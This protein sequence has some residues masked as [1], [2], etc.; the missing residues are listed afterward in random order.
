MEHDKLFEQFTLDLFS[1]LLESASTNEVDIIINTF[2]EKIC[3]YFNFETAEIYLPTGELLIL[4]GVYGLDR[5]HVCKI[6]YPTSN[7]FS[8][9]IFTDKETYIGD[10]KYFCDDETF[11]NYKT[12]LALPISSQ[13]TPIGMLVI[14]SKIDSTQDFKEDLK[15][16]EF[17]SS[18]FAMHVKNVLQMSM[19]QHKSKQLSSLSKLYL[20]LGEIVNFEGFMDYMATE[21]VH[22]FS[23][24]KILIKVKQ[25]N[26]TTLVGK[27]GNNLD[28]DRDILREN[29][30]LLNFNKKELVLINDIHSKEEYSFLKSIAERSIMFHPIT[31][32][33][34]LSGYIVI[35]D[36]LKT[37]E[38]PLGYF[39]ESDK[40]IFSALATSI[41]SKISEQNYISLLAHANCKNKQH[42]SRLNTLY[43]ISNILLDKSKEEDILFFLLTIATIGDV[44]AFNRAFAFIYDK[45]F[46]VF[47]GRMCVAPKDGEDSENIWGHI[48]TFDSYALREKILLTM[49]Q[50]TFSSSWELNQQFLNTVIPNNKN[51]K[52][53]FEVFKYKKSMNMINVNNNK[54][55]QLKQYTNMFGEKPFAIIPIVN[56]QDCIGVIVVDNTFTD[57]PIPYYD[58]DYLR[59]FGRQAAIAIEYSAIYNKSEKIDREVK[60]ARKNLIDLQ[61]LAVIGE[62]TSSTVHNLRNFMVPI[63]G[64]ANRLVKTL[65]DGKEKEYA[66]IIANEVEQLEVYIKRNLSFA[67]NAN[68]EIEEFNLDSLL[69]SLYILGKEYIKRSGKDIKFFTTCYDESA[70]V[71]W[72]YTR[73]HEVLL[74]LIVN[75]VDII[76]P[77]DDLSIISINVSKN[78]Y[79][80]N[81]IDII[82]ENTNSYIEPN[83]MHKLFTPFF[84]TKSHGIG[85]GLATCKRLIEAHDGN[86]K[87]ESKKNEFSVTTFFISLPSYLE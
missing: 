53:F 35:I 2:L 51:C 39:L 20:K 85:I 52:L 10:N 8:K 17:I 63:G 1:T 40:N 41:S 83:I 16:L 3:N 50:S 46:N 84:T 12:Q 45:E 29:L 36:P 28:L 72:D 6:Y 13:P 24:E 38:N 9:K 69:N 86:I 18:Y 67:K 5:V 78:Q 68:L 26:G 80:D 70:K 57:K 33:N 25:P 66:K 32:D 48:K 79:R 34:I 60:E 81:I 75:A 4:R 21:I 22:I 42:I 59:M 65:K 77:E 73:I 76:M 31:V 71:S 56:A 47:R 23:S 55:E 15:K 27:V 7:D 58:L 87:V 54:V 44:F 30:D 14:R 64:F 11:I 62:M 61:H 43:D 19:Y 49:D 74:D 37:A 82:V